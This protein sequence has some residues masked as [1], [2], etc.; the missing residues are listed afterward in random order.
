MTSSDDV[1][2]ACRTSSESCSPPARC[3]QA[4]SLGFLLCALVLAFIG[5][6][7][8]DV[9]LTRFI[10]SLNLVQTNDLANPWLARLSNIGDRLGKGES[11]VVISLVIWAVGF[12]LKHPVWKTAGWQSLLAHGIA[13]VVNNL[14]KHL[15]GRA[16]PKFMHAG[17]LELSPV[18]G[19]GWDSFPSGHAT[20]SFA[21]ATVLAVKFPKLRYAIWFLAFAIAASRIVRGAHFLTDVAGG[22]LLGFLIGSLAA[23]RWRDWRTSLES[24]LFALTPFLAALLAIVWTIGHHSSGLWLGPQLIDVGVIVIVLGLAGDVFLV[25]RPHVVPAFFTRP[26]AQGLIGFGLGMFTGSVWVSVTV[27]LVCVAY[28]LRPEVREE[29]AVPSR[30]IPWLREAVFSLAV[31]LALYAMIELRGA[32]PML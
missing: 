3:C 15:I 24:G 7:E 21:V 1:G 13:G 27:L 2:T 14:T 20:A 23:N 19:S 28:W 16:R 32:L 25:T 22:A 29:E 31:L 11:L 4:L 12:V 9:P 17:T 6:F 18:S 8:W 10:R 26:L 30:R 5:L